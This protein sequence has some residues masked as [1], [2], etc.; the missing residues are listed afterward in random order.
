MLR[1]W[2]KLSNSSRAFGKAQ[3]ARRSTTTWQIAIRDRFKNLRLAVGG[4]DLALH[5]PRWRTR[6]HGSRQALRGDIWRRLPIE[7]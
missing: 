5:F 2:E 7:H 4:D 1:P 3:E 6:R